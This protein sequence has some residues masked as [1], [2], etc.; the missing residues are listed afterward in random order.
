M[1][2]S[3][4]KG[5]IWALV[6]AV[7]SLG[8]ATS[9]TSEA[10]SVGSMI[11][12]DFTSQPIGHYEFCHS[13][14][15]EC[16]IRLAKNDPEVLTDKL[17]SLIESINA[18]VNKAIKPMNDIDIYGKDEVWTFPSN[19]VG[20][21]EDYVL[22]KRRELNANGM[23][24]ANLL[25]TVVRKPD[26]EGHAV[27]TVRTDRGDFILDNLHNDLRLWYNT[28]YRFLKRQSTDHTGRWVSLREEQNMLVGSLE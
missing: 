18:S 5:R 1:N 8:A 28:G 11:A 17:R 27:L 15:T 19:G 26:G 20:D 21:C 16:A 12:G 6:A 2:S 4:R 7:L 10:S 13:N 9:T 24:L 22:E 14:P 25:I 3:R 23:S